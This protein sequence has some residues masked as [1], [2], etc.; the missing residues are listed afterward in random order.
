MRLGGIRAVLFDFD[1]TLVNTETLYARSF[2]SAVKKMG[3]DKSA[4][5]KTEKDIINCYRFKMCGVRR[6]N[7]RALLSAI[8]PGIDV[9]EFQDKTY[10]GGFDKLVAEA[11]I[12]AKPGVGEVFEYLH[13]KGIA[14]GIAS[15]SKR[16]KIERFCK[17]AGIPL[18]NVSIIIGGDG[19]ANAKPNPEIYVKCME[20]L[21]V[22]PHETVV[23]EDSNV[24]AW[25]GV[26]AGCHTVVI[27]D[28]APLSP[29]T[30]R[31]VDKIL[32]KDCLIKLKGL[33]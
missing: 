23:V 20:R 7:Q 1:G 2:V 31:A 12:N 15:M 29:E 32:K 30:G 17:M 24:G 10:D 18:D 22:A 3:L 6:E 28:M 33:I 16:E 13:G 14:V 26:N 27:R 25:A 11:G 5:F 8:F 9:A 4:G 19:I 21:G